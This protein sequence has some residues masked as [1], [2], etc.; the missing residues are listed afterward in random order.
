[1]NSILKLSI[2]IKLL[3]IFLFLPT[4]AFSNN[5]PE[6]CSL[7]NLIKDI[8]KDA[9]FEKTNLQNIIEKSAY[10]SIESDSDGFIQLKEQQ[11]NELGK[12]LEKKGL[13]PDAIFIAPELRY[14]S[15]G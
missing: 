5:S 11:F 2:V 9:H 6:H 10:A 14:F 1:M 4:T 7:I 15:E 13:P 12:L 3:I 8:Q